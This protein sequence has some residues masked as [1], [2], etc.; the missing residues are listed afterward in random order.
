MLDAVVH[1]T[2]MEPQ[3]TC[4]GIRTVQWA[5]GAAALAAAGWAGAQAVGATAPAAVPEAAATRPAPSMGHM[6]QRPHRMHRHASPAEREAAAARMEA[7]H[8][9]LGN[10]QGDN[11]YERNALARCDVFKVDLDRQACVGRVRNGQASGSVESGGVL[12]EYIQ[13]VPANR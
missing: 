6:H 10:G 1:L 5:I 13:Q 12:R 3:M 4:F 9:R 11:P 8:G 2:E 7:H